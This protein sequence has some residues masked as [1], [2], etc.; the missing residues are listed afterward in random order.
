[1]KKNGINLVIEEL[2]QRLIAKKTEV[3]RYEQRISQFRQNQLF[4]VNQKQVY[5]DLNGEKQGDRIIPNSEDSIK[6]WS[7]IWSIRKKHNQHNE[8]LKSCRKQF[9]NVNSMEKVEISQ[10]MVKMQCRKMPNWK[11]PGKDGVEGYWL[12][13]LTSLHPRISVQLNQILGGERPLPDWMT[14]GKTVLVPKRSGKR[15]CS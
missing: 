5:K 2:K 14:F 3:K 7:D 15:K 6:F 4:Q 9:E 1:M 13:N 12:K 11:T 8:W 10:E